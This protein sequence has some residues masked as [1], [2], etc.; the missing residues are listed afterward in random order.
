MHACM[1]SSCVTSGARDA[2]LNAFLSDVS[3]AQLS[4]L[5]CLESLSSELCHLMPSNSYWLLLPPV[6]ALQSS[7]PCYTRGSCNV[8]QGWHVEQHFCTECFHMTCYT[9]KASRTSSMC[10]I[11]QRANAHILVFCRSAC[12][13]VCAEAITALL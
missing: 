9:E 6:Q 3:L 13:T 7:N 4:G 5:H 10:T 8:R 12:I 11:T 1:T 2:W